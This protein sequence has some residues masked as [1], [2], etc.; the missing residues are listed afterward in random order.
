M[1]IFEMN[2]RLGIRLKRNSR[3]GGKAMIKLYEMAEAL[4]ASPCVLICLRKKTITSYKGSPANPGRQHSLLFL[5]KK[6]KG[7]VLS[8]IR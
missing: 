4:S 3:D 5:T 6:G 2:G 8:M 1:F 7:G